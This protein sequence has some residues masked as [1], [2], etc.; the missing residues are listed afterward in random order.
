MIMWRRKEKYKDIRDAK[1]K[2]QKEVEVEVRVVGG[3]R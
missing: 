1:Q 2:M 3:G